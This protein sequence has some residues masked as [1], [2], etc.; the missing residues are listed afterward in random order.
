MTE[1]RLLDGDKLRV[2]VASVAAALPPVGP[3]HTLII[4]GGSLLAWRGLR[5]ATEDVATICRI[6]EELRTAV[7]QVATRHGLAANWL[8][9]HAAPFSPVTLEVDACEL[10]FE[11]PR[12]RVLGA[13]LCDVFLMKL[14]RADP[15]DLADMQ[16]IWPQIADQFPSAAA[17]V[18]AY[19]AAFPLAHHDEHLGAFIVELLA[20]AGHDL[21]TM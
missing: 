10:F 11:H 3:Q 1:P 17:V 7:Q 8:N 13:P 15:N 2:L 4:V 5:Q 9:D 6:D 16:V 18:A 14:Y 21:P 19:Q 20:A 12:L